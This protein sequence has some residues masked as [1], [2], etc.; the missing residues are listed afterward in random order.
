MVEVIIVQPDTAHLLD[1][2]EEDVFD[3]DVQ[4]E[5]LKEFLANS[6][7]VLAIAL[8]EG[9]VVGMA[10]GIAYVHPDKALAL[11]I[12][13]VGVA[14]RLHQ[15]GIGSRLVKRLLEW[16]KARGCREA[17][18]ATEVENTPARRLYESTGGRQEED[19]AVVYVYP[20]CTEGSKMD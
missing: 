8:S 2:V 4:P 18:V 10:T 1:L 6:S 7:N 5:L 15:Q 16:G 11:F 20:L 14:P 12:N 9:R 17:W 19:L 3:H 13:E